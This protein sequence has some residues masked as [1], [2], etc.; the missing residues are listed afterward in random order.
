M[1]HQ[2]T[3]RL[4]ISR[5]IKLKNDRRKFFKGVAAS[6]LAATAMGSQLSLSGKTAK[7]RTQGYKYKVAYTWLPQMGSRPFPS[8]SSSE[9]DDQLIEDYR[10]VL[11]SSP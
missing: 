3:R 1:N 11:T 7:T 8:L 5:R 4:P 2:L 9:L 6:G 10:R